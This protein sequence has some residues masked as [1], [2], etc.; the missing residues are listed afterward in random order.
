VFI[1]RFYGLHCCIS[2]ALQPREHSVYK[3]ILISAC[4][5]AAITPAISPAH[6]QSAGDLLF[7]SFNADEDGW[8]MVTLVDL[9]ANTKVY[10]SDNEWSGTAF[11]GGESFSSWTTG[12]AV[13]AAGTVVRFTV[14]EIGSRLSASVGSFVRETVSGSSNVGVNQSSDTVYAYLGTSATTPTTFL[15]AI[16]NGTFGLASDGTLT[17]T[18]LSVGSGAVQLTRS[19]DYAEYTG[20][21]DNQA[22]FA[23]YKAVVSNVAN[24]TVRG[25]GDFANTVPSTTAFSVTPIPEPGTWALMAAG[26][27]AVGFVAKRRS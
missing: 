23:G 13:I 22:A 1:V 17:N 20:L 4:I 26:L 11:N 15:A 8:A 27:M 9:A 5:A 7:T 3:R 10:F 25:D 14:I 21:R 24:W 18:G 2:N 12:P 19:S 6:A 16:S